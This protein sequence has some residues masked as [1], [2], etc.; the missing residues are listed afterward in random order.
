MHS[1]TKI[2][3]SQ[4]GHHKN[5]ISLSSTESEYLIDLNEEISPSKTQH[6]RQQY[7]CTK[8]SYNIAVLATGNAHALVPPSSSNNRPVSFNCKF[9]ST[10][11][12][13]MRRSE[14]R[15][16]WKPLNIGKGVRKATPIMF[17]KWLG[18]SNYKAGQD[19]EPL[20]TSPA[21][22]Q[23]PKYKET[24]E[25]ENTRHHHDPLHSQLGINS[26]GGEF[27]CKPTVPV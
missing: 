11:R 19:W 21:D 24:L 13:V 9:S 14:W 5:F 12:H 8:V 27:I 4:W 18:S 25:A 1:S 23:S 15:Y 10:Q 26:E 3:L 22:H 2:C 7:L 6:F 20:I 16:R 17:P